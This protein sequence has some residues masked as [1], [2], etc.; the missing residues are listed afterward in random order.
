MNQRIKKF[1]QR[2]SGKSEKYLAISLFIIY[3]ILL[4]VFLNIDINKIDAGRFDL[5]LGNHDI[6]KVVEDI[7]MS[8]ADYIKSK[9][10]SFVFDTDVE[11]KIIACDPEKIERILL[12]LL[13]NA[14]KF[15]K[16]GGSV[17]VNINDLSDFIEISVQDTGIGIPES[18]QFLVFERFVQ[19][20][21]SLSRNFE[22]SGIGLALVRNLVEMHDGN[23]RLESEEGKGS[24]FIISLPC[25]TIN[26]G[27]SAISESSNSTSGSDRVLKI[28]IELSDIYF[29]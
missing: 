17:A 19:L 20:D 14:I 13:S 29:N 27:T 3:S 4:F 24:K 25:K 10:I 23:I 1:L 11:E 22:G 8:V 16:T 15:T 2:F 6:I 21:N 26:E 7:C 5:N 9:D 18:K 28:N 12:N